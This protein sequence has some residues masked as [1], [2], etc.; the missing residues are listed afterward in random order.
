MRIYYFGEL[1]AET[2]IKQKP[3]DKNIKQPKLIIRNYL[4]EIDS[5]QRESGIPVTIEKRGLYA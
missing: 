1:I 2:E 4:D 3:T 5:E